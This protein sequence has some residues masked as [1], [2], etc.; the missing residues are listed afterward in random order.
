MRQHQALIQQLADCAAACQ[1]CSD[2]CLN[3]DDVKMMV[4]CIRRDRDC[5]DAC[6][7]ALNAVSRGSESASKVVQLCLELC[8]QC[9]EECGKHEAQHC[10]ECAEACRACEKACEEFLG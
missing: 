6:L 3:E 4:S 2:Q 1:Y 7:M 8:K 5:A 10:K 9:A